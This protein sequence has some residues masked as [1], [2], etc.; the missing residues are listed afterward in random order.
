MALMLACRALQRA[1]SQAKTTNLTLQAAELPQL[2]C[3]C[4]GLGVAHNSAQSSVMAP[5]SDQKTG[6]FAQP[7]FPYPVFFGRRWYR[8][9][10]AMST[11]V[12]TSH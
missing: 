2:C 1:L 12:V 7:A 3:I 4:S 9:P 10:S 11:S 8:H 6:H 5:H